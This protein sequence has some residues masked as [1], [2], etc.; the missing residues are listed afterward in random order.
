M[1]IMMAIPNASVI[2]L[3]ASALALWFL[4]LAYLWGSKKKETKVHHD[5]LTLALMIVGVVVFVWMIP[6]AIRILDVGIDLGA[7]WY[8]TLMIIVGSITFALTW[9]IPLL[10]LMKG[11]KPELTAKLKLWMRIVLI[12]WIVSFVI[13]IV[14]FLMLYVLH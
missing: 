5:Y 1:V 8:L 11:Q 12:L 2:V 14:N 9:I 13:G 10:Y 6:Q 4:I 7:Y 3:A